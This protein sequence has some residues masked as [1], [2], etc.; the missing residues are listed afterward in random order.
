MLKDQKKEIKKEEWIINGN[1]IQGCNE[2]LNIN[3]P[4]IMKE[5]HIDYLNAGANIIMGLVKKTNPFF[6][7]SRISIVF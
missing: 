5:V 1:N 2:I 6:L 4:H 3:A 7:F